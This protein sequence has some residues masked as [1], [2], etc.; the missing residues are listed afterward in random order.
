MKE[1]KKTA[2]VVNDEPVQLLL[3]SSHLEKLGFA[4]KAH[5]SAEAA[6]VSFSAGF[7][8]DIIVTDLNMPDM[9]GWRFCRLLGSPEFRDMNDIPI[10]AVSA[11]LIGENVRLMSLEAGADAFLA[12]PFDFARIKEAVSA[13]LEGRKLSD[14]VAILVVDDD[15]TL[16]RMVRNAFAGSSWRI[17]EAFTAQEARELIAQEVV[18]V[19]LL[20]Y[21]LPDTRDHSFLTELKSLYPGITVVMMTG[22]PAP[23]LAAQLLSSGAAAYIR[24]PFSPKNI[25][26]ICRS[27]RDHSFLSNIQNML[28]KRTGELRDGETKYRRL[29]ESAKDGILLLDAETGRILDVNPSLIELLGYPREELLQKTF[30]DIKAF[31]TMAASKGSFLKLQNQ[32]YVRYEDRPV[33][34]RDGR[35]VDV[36]FAANAYSVDDK[37]V[38]Q[39]NV[40]DITG[41]KQAEEAIRRSE[42]KFLKAFSRNASLMAISTVEE[43]RFLDVND[44]FLKCTGYRREEVVGKTSK[45]LGIFAD[46]RQRDRILLCLKKRG[47][48][49]D[50][51][52]DIKTSSG[53]IRHGIFSADVVTLKKEPYLLT[54]MADITERRQAEEALRQS[55]ELLNMAIE[56][57]GVG[58]WDWKIQ[59]GE[60]FFNERWAQIVGYS[61]KELEPISIETW[62]RLV[63][64]DDRAKSDA[65]IREH[66]AGQTTT[67]E[68]EARMKHRDGHWIWVL[69]RGKVTERD[70]AGNPV[71]MTGTHLDITERKRTEDE[72]KASEERFRNIYSNSPVAIELYDDEGTLIDVNPACCSLFGID[73]AD[74]VRGFRLFDDP[75]IPHDVRERLRKGEA[76]RHEI[77]FDFELVKR[78]NLYATTR[79]G[80]I[81]LD[82]LV[83]RL[84]GGL[85]ITPGYMAQIIDI[86]DRRKMESSIRSLNE[87]LEEKVRE[88]TRDLVDINKELELFVHAVSHDLRGP[89]QT[90]VGFS[91]ALLEDYA[92]KLDGDGQESLRYLHRETM[93]LSSMLVGLLHLSRASRNPLRRVEIDLTAMAREIAGELATRQP[94]R[95]V[96]VAVADGMRISGDEGLLR[97]LMTNLIGNAWKFTG[98]VPNATIEIGVLDHAIEPVFYVR[99]NGAGFD[100]AYADKLFTPFKRLHSAGEFQGTGMG[101][102]TAK[103]IVGRHGGRIWAE[104]EVGKGA[105]FCFTLGQSIEHDA[106][107]PSETEKKQ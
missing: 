81:T 103:R 71:R 65:L 60:T 21:H 41:R 26:E 40:R 18:D 8:P 7:R 54:Q 22:D 94:E 23:E 101:L 79:R 36:E 30:W 17:L 105:K 99:D 16:C 25:V 87:H 58:L 100:M 92:D 76:I 107:A 88:R 47:Y 83:T 62:K 91:Q 11:V 95:M 35:Q 13:L 2:V 46:P 29:F 14:L 56:G 85:G 72:L 75:N 28:Q 96:T 84:G 1:H 53:D 66:F 34:T 24:K 49:R 93:K 74:A 10:L 37:K 67:Y 44:A 78:H 27:A 51:D 90:M 106:Q 48:C 3:I 20:D 4:V 33:K 52:V 31:K 5:T 32:D 12:A 43:G 61:L 64:P 80:T 50:V 104:S 57:S 70:E 6:L 69:D 42:E 102:A 55:K 59:T 19:V 89:M 45:E 68:C 86:T 63:H 15:R 38:I 39:C 97:N 9:D 73:S 98:K 77:D 82:I